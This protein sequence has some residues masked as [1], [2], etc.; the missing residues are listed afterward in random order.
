MQR[1][2]RLS[3]ILMAAGGVAGLLVGLAAID[4]RVG[5]EMRALVGGHKPSGDLA[6]LGAG[7]GRLGATLLE[8]VRDQSITHAPLTIFALGALVLVLFILRT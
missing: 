3:G 1:R 8:A 2:H 7:L 5:N 4:D 6:S